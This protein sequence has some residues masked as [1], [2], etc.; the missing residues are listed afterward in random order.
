MIPDSQD[1]KSN[2][3]YTKTGL[4]VKVLPKEPNTDAVK[5][6]M[7]ILQEEEVI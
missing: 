2:V 6:I 3:I 5:E 4:V 7:K 1:Q